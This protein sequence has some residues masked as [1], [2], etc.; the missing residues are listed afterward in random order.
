M[1]PPNDDLSDTMLD[2][3]LNEEQDRRYPDAS[4]DVQVA[5]SASSRSHGVS[6][7]L[8]E[9]AGGAM[10]RWKPRGSLVEQTDQDLDVRELMR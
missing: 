7:L 9:G 1:L 4:L 5:S 8:S 10:G 2:G 3:A 6:S